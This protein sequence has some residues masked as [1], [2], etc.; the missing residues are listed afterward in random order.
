M[1]T[2]ANVEDARIHPVKKPNKM[3]M[4][5]YN[6][7]YLF[8]MVAPSAL[9]IF[10]FAYLPLYGWI[11]AFKQYQIGKTM[12][13]APWVG[14]EQF[15]RF[16]LQSSDWSY[17]LVNTLVMNIGS[18]VINLTVAALFAILIN[19]LRS[20]AIARIIQ[21]IS[22]FPF[23]ISWVIVYAIMTA[24]YGVSTGAIN[25][26]LVDS[27]IL[28]KGLNILGDPKYSW[29]LIFGINLWKHLGYN[30]VIFIAAIASISSEQYE[31]AEIDGASRLQKVLYITIPG[32]MPTLVVLLIINSG[33][34]L[35]SNIEMFFLFTNSVNWSRMEVLDMYILKYGLQLNNYSYATAIGII[36]SIISIMIIMGVNSFAKRVTGRGIL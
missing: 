17:L 9:L 6:Q 30:S 32:L 8:L 1:S 34:V 12:L 36:K 18:I 29:G 25:V 26:T 10:T 3:R 7:R 14:M 13:N 23:F 11:I 21:T 2:N 27:G 35:N 16:I 4:K 20:R 31:A 19:E 28:E 15:K 22:F 33:W 24:L 5:I